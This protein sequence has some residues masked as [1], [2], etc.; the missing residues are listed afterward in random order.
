LGGLLVDW[1]QLLVVLRTLGQAR[2]FSPIVLRDS[3]LLLSQFS[4]NYL[5]FLADKCGFALSSCR[6]RRGE[7]AN[8]KVM[9]GETARKRD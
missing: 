3:P 4:Q 1:G 5:F 7:E 2:C 6:M 9:I 8:A